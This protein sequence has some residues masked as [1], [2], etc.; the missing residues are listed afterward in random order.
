MVKGGLAIL[1][2]LI[3]ERDEK[4]HELFLLLRRETKWF[5][6]RIHIRQIET[7]EIPTPVVELDDLPQRGHAAV[8]KVRSG[9]FGITQ[10]WGLEGP[11]DGDT[12]ERGPDGFI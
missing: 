4:R 6:R 12:L 7:T 10:A 2:P 11:I 1:H 9:Q 8:M 3:G 5:N